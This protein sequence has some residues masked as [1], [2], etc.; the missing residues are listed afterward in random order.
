MYKV[1]AIMG[2]SASGKT[3]LQ[4]A[5]AREFDVNEIVSTTTRPKGNKRKS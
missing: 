3:T 4:K 2:K 1:V 5:I